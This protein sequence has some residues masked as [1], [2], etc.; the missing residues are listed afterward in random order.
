MRLALQSPHGCGDQ[1]RRR[2]LLPGAEGQPGKLRSDARS[3]F[4]KLSPDHPAARQEGAGHGR[5]ETR[6]G[7]VISAKGLAEP[8][9]FPGLKAFGRIEDLCET[10][11]T[12]QTETR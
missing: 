9:D 2:R 3:G 8:H 1:R 4:G 6:T 7:T 12:L 5:K 10:D 11:G